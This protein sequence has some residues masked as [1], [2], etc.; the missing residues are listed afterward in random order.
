[1]NRT[2]KDLIIEIEKLIWDPGTS[3]IEKTHAVQGLLYSW[4]QMQDHRTQEMFGDDDAHISKR[5]F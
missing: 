4:S 5:R 1:M 3:E 2:E